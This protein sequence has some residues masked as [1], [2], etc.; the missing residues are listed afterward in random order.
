MCRDAGLQCIE[1]TMFGAGVDASQPS[2]MEVLAARVARIKESGL[3]LW[4]VHLPFGRQW[5]LAAP[6]SEVA[7]KAVA[8]MERFLQIGTGWGAEV[9]VI[10]PST[11]PIPDEERQDYLERSRQSL[12]QVAQAAHSYGIKLAVECLP[13]TC[14][15]NTSGEMLELLAS[16]DGVGACL[17]ANHPL[18]EPSE[19]FA[20]KLS[21]RIYTVHMS[22]YDGVDE[23][24]W[25][26]GEGT[27]SWSAVIG[28][29]AEGGYPGPFMFEVGR[30]KGAEIRTPS[31]LGE[32]W[33]R[34]LAQ[35][36]ADQAS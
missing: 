3:R 25:L 11:E 14:L 32:C 24:H 15:C 22:D 23:R 12:Q 36:V 7:E 21:G 1:L 20:T 16:L 13:R 28:A 5:D 27:I 30:K 10:H 18:Q 19:E 4:S 33:R 29:L 9:A 26:P 34:L 8:S 17:D 6:D 31:D 35:Y 2:A